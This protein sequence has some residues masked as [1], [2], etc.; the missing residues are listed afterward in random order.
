MLNS[1][2]NISSVTNSENNDIFAFNIK[3]NPVIAYSEA[4]CPDFRINKF[5]RIITR[6]IL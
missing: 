3:N 1:F 5:F 2:I 4:I 6:V